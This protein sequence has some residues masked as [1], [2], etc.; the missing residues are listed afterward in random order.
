[1][2]MSQARRNRAKGFRGERLL[3]KYLNKHGW[4]AKRLPASIVDGI[5]TKENRIALFEVKVTR[6]NT[7]KIPKKQVERLHKWLEIFD[8]FVSREAVAAVRFTRH[9]KWVFIQLKEVKE[10]LV[11]HDQEG[12]W[13]P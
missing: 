12:D 3:M 7:A 1:M 6:K 4:K 9:R 13:E 10:Y 11:N 5:A 2:R 8:C